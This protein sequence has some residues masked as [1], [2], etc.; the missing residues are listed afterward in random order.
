MGLLLRL[1]FFAAAIVGAA[2]LFVYAA[3]VATIFIPVALFVVFLLRRKGTI[4][5]TT[6]DLRQG[7]HAPRSRPPVIDQDPNDVTVERG[8]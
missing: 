4:V 3:V 8:R 1:T 5:W 6:A 2:L 7:G